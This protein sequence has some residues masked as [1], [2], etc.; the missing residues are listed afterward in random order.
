MPIQVTCPGCLKRFSVGDQFAG[1]QGP[2]PKCKTL[3]TI[4]KLED[5]VV[6]HAPVE[7]PTDAK[8]RPILKTEKVKDAKFQPII[9]TVVISIVLATL[10]AAFVLRGSEAAQNFAVLGGGAILLGPLVAWGGY[11]FLRDS[12]LEPYRGAQLWLRATICGLVYALAWLVFWFIIGRVEPDYA[13]KGL[14]IFQMLIPSI[15]A[16]VIGTLAAYVT[17]DLEPFNAFFHCAMYFVLTGLLR[18]ILELPPL[19]G[20]WPST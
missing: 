12:E 13:T 5:Q 6:I 9:A 19:P 3:I 18:W 14:A 2:C 11:A 8:G 20:L 1:K 4:P 15:L 17:L 10:L 16:F 7:G